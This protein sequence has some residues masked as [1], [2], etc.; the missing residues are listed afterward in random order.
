MSFDLA[1]CNGII[2]SSHN[3]YTPILGSIGISDGL[4]AYVGEKNIHATDAKE[5]IDATGKIVMPGLINGHCHGDMTLARGLGDDL[6]L[7][8]QNDLFNPIGWFYDQLSLDDFYYA[9]QL[10]YIEA[11]LS[12]TTFI[13]ENAFWSLGSKSFDAFNSVGIKG[14]V[15]EDIVVDFKDMDKRKTLEQINAFQRDCAA[16]NLIPVLGGVLEEYYQDDI[17]EYQKSIMTQSD[18]LW[19]SHL[20]ETLWRKQYLINGFNSSAVQILEDYETLSSNYLGSHGVYLSKNDIRL[21][22]ERHAKI[23]NTPLCEMKIADGIAPVPELIENGITVGLGTD[24]AMWNNSNDMFREMKGLSLINSITRGSRTI[25]TSDILDMGTINGAKVFGL[26][27]EM[28]TL[29]VGKKADLIMINA[30]QPHMAPLR[31]KSSQNVLSAVVFCATGQDVSHVVI[32]GKL[33]VENRRLLTIDVQ[34]VIDKVTSS[35]EKIG[36]YMEEVMS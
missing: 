8:E 28:G 17:L 25:P 14:G 35:S 29:E 32:D 10:T 9:R 30:D 1:I 7:K 2:I 33:I 20:S 21:L 12:G 5:I 34:D 26:E 11:L 18:C 22:K 19:T 31:T 24:G 3:C 27:K 13:L 23:V 6:T 36:K 15:V 4:I 16:K